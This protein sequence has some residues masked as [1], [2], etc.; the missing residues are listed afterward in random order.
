MN[1]SWKAYAKE[2]VEK[3]NQ[4]YL[5]GKLERLVRYFSDESAIKHEIARWARERKMF[6]ERGIHPLVSKIEVVPLKH[7]DLQEAEVEAMLSIH[8]QMYYMQGEATF[9]Q[10]NRR[11]Q[12]VRMRP[13][14]YGWSFIRPWGWYFQKEN[15]AA[16]SKENEDEGKTDDPVTAPDL[17]VPQE[18]D[19]QETETVPQEAKAPQETEQTATRRYYN[20]HKAVEYAETYW[21]H[22]N[23]AFRTFEVDCTNFVSQCLYAGGIPMVFTSNRG[24][25]WWYKGSSWSYSWAVANSLYLLLGS[26]KAPFYA[27]KVHSPAELQIGDVICY[28]FDGDGR[29]QHNTFV[30]AKDSQGMPLVNARTTD[31]RH[32]YWEYKDSSAYTDRIQYSFFHIYGKISEPI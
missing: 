9:K 18:A 29:W 10:E 19:A 22:P 2:Y 15:L 20:R 13:D 3:L 27:K 11:I 14:K 7:V 4:T 17:A 24:T 5:D 21:N 31:S 8:Q 32:R 30:V 16:H 6:A 26:G 1:H 12:M 23:P 25:G 28:D